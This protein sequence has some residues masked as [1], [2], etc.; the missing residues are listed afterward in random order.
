MS[1]TIKY[2]EAKWDVTYNHATGK[3]IGEFFTQLRDNQVLLGKHCP[4]CDRVLTPARSFCDRCYVETDNFVEVGHEG[5]IQIYT[6]VKRAFKGLPEPPYIIA[7]V[8]L[9][10]ADTAMLNFVKGI[11]VENPED[12]AKLQ[13]GARVKVVFKKER[14]GR[15]LDFWYE[16]I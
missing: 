15:I 7:Y 2:F 10:G 4:K 12:L 8:L 5:T 6:Y 11:D 16:L 9:D 13:I 14:E 1:E 3:T